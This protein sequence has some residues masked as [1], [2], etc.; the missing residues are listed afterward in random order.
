MV[1]EIDY[2]GFPVG[3]FGA[4]CDELVEGFVGR[5]PGVGVSFTV[6]RSG[7][8]VRRSVYGNKY[9]KVFWKGVV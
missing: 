1:V 6:R 2:R 8:D 4:L 9:M 3:P 7:I 5:C